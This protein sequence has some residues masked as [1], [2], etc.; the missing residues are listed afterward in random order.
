MLKMVLAVA[1]GSALGGV[2]RF[3]IQ[4]AVKLKFASVFPWATWSINL[5]GS[6][7]IGVFFSYFLRLRMEQETLA[8][9]LMTGICGGFTTFSAFSMENV[10]LIREGHLMTAS[11]YI[12]SAV[13][14]GIVCCF[15]G[16]QLAK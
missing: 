3:L 13:G 8:V 16:M 1:M 6:F 10:Q 14:L 12:L 15:A 11:L 4:A 5:F 2:A 9:F 7:L